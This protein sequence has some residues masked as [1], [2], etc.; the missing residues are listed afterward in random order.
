M[1]SVKVQNFSDKTIDWVDKSNNLLDILLQQMDI[2]HACGGKGRCTTCKVNVI[3]SQNMIRE[4]S[5][6]EN[7][8]FAQ[9]R[10]T[11]KQR[12]SCQFVPTESL[13]IEIPEECKLP[14]QKYS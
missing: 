11:S 3:E 12:L 1:P 9:H 4:L 10:L 14:H 2:M 6:V 8:F 5:E 13:V 7:K